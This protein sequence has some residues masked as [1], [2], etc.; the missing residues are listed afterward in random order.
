MGPPAPWGEGLGSEVSRQRSAEAE[1]EEPPG[2]GALGDQGH[3]GRRSQKREGRDQGCRCRCP[4]LQG[5]S[6]GRGQPAGQGVSWTALVLGPLLI[7]SPAAARWALRL[8]PASCLGHLQGCLGAQDPISAARGRGQGS[9][10]GQDTAL[11]W[12]Q[13]R[14]CSG[15]PVAQALSPRRWPIHKAPGGVAPS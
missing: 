9:R 3:K 2:R 13:R 7:L 5:R 6:R 11:V 4:S 8:P 10:P 15:G 12:G 1:A 14:H